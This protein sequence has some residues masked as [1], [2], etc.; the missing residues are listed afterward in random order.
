MVREVSV[1]V[2]LQPPYAV[3]G[4]SS[5]PMIVLKRPLPEQLIGHRFDVFRKGKSV[6]EVSTAMGK[7]GLV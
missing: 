7:R 4:S 5:I 3:G 2:C 6:L 1:I